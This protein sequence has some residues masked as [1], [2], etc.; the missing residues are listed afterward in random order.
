[1]TTK[2]EI[3]LNDVNEANGIRFTFD[4][5]NTFDADVD[6]LPEAMVHRLAVHG[7]SQKLGDSYAGATG[8][9]MTSDDVE[10]GVRELYAALK[11][12]S[13]GTGR[14]STGGKLF[15]AFTRWAM[16]NGKTVAEAAD[17][18]RDLS[19][20]DKKELRKAAPI[21]AHLAAIEAERAEALA[22]AADDSDADDLTAKY[23]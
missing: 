16:E 22:K 2:K 11:S 15:V 5:G 6:S 13:F 21:K 14:T 12:G 8:K 23:F 3:I 17:A 7:L 18:F 20:E 9:G 19:D 4:N 1:M 10:Q